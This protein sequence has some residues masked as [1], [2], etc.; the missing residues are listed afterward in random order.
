MKNIVVDFSQK[1]LRIRQQL[2]GIF[3]HVIFEETSEKN[4]K[5]NFIFWE[6]KL[7]KLKRRD[8]K[9]I[10]HVKVVLFS[11]SFFAI[12]KNYFSLN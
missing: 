9:F 11:R 10:I 1:Q 6:I 3:C 2:A 7:A 12:R 5:R 4:L 8:T